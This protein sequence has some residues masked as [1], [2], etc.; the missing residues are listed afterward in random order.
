MKRGGLTYKS[1]GV[2]IAAGDK[3][4]ATIKKLVRS[5]FNPNVLREIGSFGSFYAADF[6]GYRRPVLISS[7][8][9]VGTKLKI[10]FMADKHDTVGED[11]VNHCVNDIMV[12]G[13]KPLYFLDYFGTGKLKSGVMEQVITG[14]ARGCKAN[15]CALIG[16]ETAEMPGFYQ[17][18]EY[19][20]A[21]FIVG[22]V[23]KG[24]IIDGSRIK[25]GD[26]LIGLESSGL[27]TNGF[28]LVRKLLFDRLKYRLSRRIPE[29]G[30]TLAEELLRVH[31]SYFKVV[32]KLVNDVKV[33]GMAHITGGGISGNL[34]RILPR[35]CRADVDRASWQV[36]PLFTLIQRLGSVDTDEMFRTF[37]MGIGMIVVVGRKD[38]D[39]ALRLLKRG[40]VPA[41]VLG[42]ISKGTKRVRLV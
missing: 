33:K 18:G 4:T 26:V 32:S 2:D 30:C 8:D 1:A 9:G 14:L 10:A 38:V 42:E 35:G 39:N 22:V 24:E 11:L 7:A 36:P 27:H 21:G 6:A 40:R 34:V 3:A 12:Q 23:G 41:Y 25:P 37:N 29:L 28:S 17:R 19:D 16:G 15:K 31:R 5:T 13:A 20:L